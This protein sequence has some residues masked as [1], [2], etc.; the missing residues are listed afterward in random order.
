MVVNLGIE[1]LSLDGQG[2][3]EGDPWVNT[4]VYKDLEEGSDL[5]TDSVSRRRLS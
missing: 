2:I 4:F 5:S 3:V 1:S